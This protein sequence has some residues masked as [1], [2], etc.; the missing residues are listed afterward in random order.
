MISADSPQRNFKLKKAKRLGFSF[1]SDEDH[2]V[3]DLYQVPI[4]RKH[5][6]SA[7]YRDGFIQPAIFAFKGEENVFTF[8]QNPKSVNLWGAMGRPSPKEVL[9]ILSEKI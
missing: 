3:A 2:A 6:M 9:S 1:L 4:Q 8:I 5:P 7:T